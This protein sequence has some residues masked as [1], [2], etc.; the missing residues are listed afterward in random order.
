MSDTANLFPSTVPELVT[1]DL[2]V[3][4][5]TATLIGPEPGADLI[6][7]V[8]AV[9]ILVPILVQHHGKA[10]YALV[11]GR[12]RLQAARA[13]GLTMIP[14]RVI[15]KDI[16]NPGAYTLQANLTRRAN[17]VSEYL[18]ICDLVKAGYT[19]AAIARTLGIATGLMA[20]RLLLGKLLG[21]LFDLLAAGKIVPSVGEGAARL[22]LAA[23]ERLLALY[24]ERGKLTMR[25][26]AEVRRV[27]R[28]AAARSLS[29]VVFGSW[30][31]IRR[32]AQT[33]LTHLE[34][35]HALCASL[36]V[37]FNMTEVTERIK[38]ML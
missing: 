38:A 4:L 15:P 26:I 32:D 11:D 28:A 12:R 9:G 3:D 14:A 36:G 23:Q 34:A 2:P 19:E 13:A 17:A 37:P 16:L 7:S 25:D 29:D 22:P 1:E 27:D 24:Q 8:A 18:A 20:R 6:A 30:D 31:D 5:I 33:A 21:P 10:A 35:A